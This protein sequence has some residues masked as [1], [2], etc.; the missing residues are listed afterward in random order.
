MVWTVPN[1]LTVL[2]IALIPVLVLVF[3]LPFAWSNLASTAVFGLAALTDWFDGYL[4]R[5]L[6]QSSPFGA[7]LDPVADKLIVAVAL[8]M[9]VQ[10]NP[11]WWFV[12]PAAVIVGREIAISALR[13]W[14]AEIGERAQVAVSVIGK[15]KTT[16]QMVALLLLLYREPLWAL[17]TR[18]IGIVL[19][20]MAAILTLWSMVIYLRAAWPLLAGGEKS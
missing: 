9:L 6:G 19:L 15:I 17:P 1:T 10:A 4:A 2:R 12:I 20:Y 8:V 16:A 14:M 11:K 3:Y 5:K 13:E 7:F 18:D